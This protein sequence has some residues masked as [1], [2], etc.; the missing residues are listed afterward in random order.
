MSNPDISAILE[1]WRFEEDNN[2]RKI[3]DA[4]GREK[5][6]V[7]VEEGPFSGL[8]QMDLDGRPDGARPHGRAF[9][10][11]F[12]RDELRR[13]AQ[14]CGSE[15][16]FSLGHAACEELFDESHR[17]YQRYVFCLRMAEFD[18]VVRDTERNMRAFRFVR[19]YAEQESDRDHLERW[20]PYIL[21][22]N[23]TAR[24]MLA[25]RGGNFQAALSTVQRVRQRIK[26]LGE[27]DVDE[28]A[29]ERER[30]LEMLNEM[31]RQIQ[32][33]RPLSLTERLEKQLGKAVRKEEYER[34]A[35][36]RDRLRGIRGD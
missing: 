23:A 15:D 16:G 14:Q 18:L 9:A 4:D 30:S 35:V 17:V 3:V 1:G 11:D 2:V 13:F 20:W 31:E 26:R 25:I 10:L 34:A 6:Q 28:F 21:R 36:L 22:I 27:M 8:L 12:W 5:I 33:D 29:V 19:R 24:V 7:R 32:H